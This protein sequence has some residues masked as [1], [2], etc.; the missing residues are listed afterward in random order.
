M[1]FSFCRAA[2]LVLLGMVSLTLPARAQF[3][4]QIGL[5]VLRNTTTNLN[6]AGVK[7]GQVEAASPSFEVSPSAVGQP[8]NLFTWIAQTVPPVPTNVSQYFPA[9][10]TANT[11]T[12]SLGTESD[13]ADNVASNF[14][15]MVFGVATNVA[16]VNNYDVYTFYYHYIFY[17]NTIAEHI[18]NQ[19]F[20][21]QVVDTNA[22]QTYDDYAAQHNVLFVS[23]AGL[24]GQPVNSPA[25][26]YNGIAVGVY[27]NFDSPHGPTPDGRSKPDIT[28]YGFPDS[29][30]S[31]S[32][33]LVSGAAA[34][35]M[36]AGG[37]GDGGGGGVTNCAKDIRTL[38][39]LL[40][41]GAVKPA[42]W[43]NSPSAPLDVRY[44]AGV[45]NV[46]N[47]YVQLTGG[48]HAP[49]VST[50]VA[51]NDVHPP[52]GATGTI[53]TLSGWDFNT[54]TSSSTQDRVSH[55]YFNVTNGTGNFIATATLVWNRQSGNTDINNLDLFLYDCASSNLVMCSTSLV[56][57]VEQVYVP[58]L[59]PGRYDLQA[60]K[61]GG[62]AGSG[63]V[64]NSE[65]Y[66]L[67]WQF[68]P[69]PVLGLDVSTNF[70]LTWPVYPAGY[71]LSSATNLTAPVWST[72][73][74]PI[75]TI[76]NG[77][78]RIQVDATNEIQFFRL[79]SL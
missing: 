44:G 78:N 20:T 54:N 8:T 75:P 34:V 2:I 25:T 72:N 71:V 33:P 46:Y 53:S 30:T 57:N 28:A 26:C 1:P 16:H 68:V 62:D 43:S 79:R 48:R 39:A 70:L 76:T 14:F 45:L 64:T 13:H 51:T 5:T 17:N 27:N 50:S 3:L 15:G 40:L 23:G 35:L 4:D 11:F 63:N 67:A 12:N 7:V 37:R 32:T 61:A 65:P 41:D 18:V 29:V 21:F 38:K 59:P 22:D 49:V 10:L 69:V 52:T 56:D 74:L 9:P 77:L 6:G 47:S 58:N 55:Y 42:G 73:N 60:W 24:N 19:S 66:A 36:Q 31:Y